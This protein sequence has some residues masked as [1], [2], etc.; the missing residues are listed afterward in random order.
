MSEMKLWTRE[1]FPIVYEGDEPKAVLVDV[2][3]FEQIELI[4][5]NLL[6]REGEP[7][8]QILVASGILRRL[9]EQA[10]QPCFP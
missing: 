4:L 9:V 7:E 8:D 2:A 5:D 1:R 3:T 10:Q 6:N